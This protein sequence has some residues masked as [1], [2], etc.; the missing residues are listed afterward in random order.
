MAQAN[1][2]VGGLEDEEMLSK[3]LEERIIHA[4]WKVRLAAYKEVKNMFQNDFAQFEGSKANEETPNGNP[5]HLNSF[6]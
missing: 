6:D 1:T 4:N 3:P 5:E 2:N